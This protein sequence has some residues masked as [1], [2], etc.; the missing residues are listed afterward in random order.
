MDCLLILELIIK[1]IEHIIYFK[2][3]HIFPIRQL[4]FYFDK[5]S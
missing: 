3:V 5:N 1:K 2:E 4:F